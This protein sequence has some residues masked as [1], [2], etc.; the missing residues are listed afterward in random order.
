MSPAYST[1]PTL[2]DGVVTLRAPIA[3]D[4]MGSFEQC[5]DPASQQWTTIPVPYTLD[6][7]N[8]Y[9]YHFIP[10][11]WE[12]GQEWGF[13]VEAEDEVGARRFCG[14]IS[15]RNLG[16]SR[17]EIAFGAHPWARG[18]GI[19]ERG[20]RMLIEWGFREQHLNTIEWLSPRGNWSS[21]RLAWKLGF[22]Y[23]GV[24]RHWLAQRGQLRDAWV[25]TLRRGEEIRPRTPWLESPTLMGPSVTLRTLAETDLPRIVESLADQDTQH[26]LQTVR[27]SAPHTLESNAEYVVEGLEDAAA[28]RAVHWAV[29][30]QR[31]DMYVG[32]VSLFSLKYKREAEM[33]F[34]MHP[35]WRRRGW[36]TEACRLVVKHAYIPMEDGGLGLRRLTADACATNEGSMRVLERSGFLRI[37]RSRQST[38]RGDDKWMDTHLYDQLISDRD[39]SLW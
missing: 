21:W 38:L 13:V 28:G 1:I 33:T 25:G 5:Q 2:T 34:W 15:L 9:M 11:G 35:H 30:D 7:A 27:E 3:S 31:T 36:A 19:M 24:L 29:T 26:W 23:E 22:S 6:D 14:T 12:T 16:E 8:I 39:R 18:R 4:V 37:G 17:A 10:R 20:L 32:Q